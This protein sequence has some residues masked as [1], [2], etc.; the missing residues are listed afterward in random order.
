MFEGRGETGKL[1]THGGGGT[2][3]EL[4]AH[5]H[6]RAANRRKYHT[7]DTTHRSVCDA[8]PFNKFAGSIFFVRIPSFIS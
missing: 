8:R 1:Y 5:H 7:D 3:G 4:I 6:V 2:S